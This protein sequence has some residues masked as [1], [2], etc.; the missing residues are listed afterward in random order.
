MLDP[1]G[2]DRTL[3]FGS[4]NFGH[5]KIIVTSESCIVVVPYLLSAKSSVVMHAMFKLVV[6]KN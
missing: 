5:A 3:V 1:T 4:L 6:F 2:I